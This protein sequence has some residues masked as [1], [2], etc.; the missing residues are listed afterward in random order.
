MTQARFRRT[1]A[2]SFLAAGALVPPLLIAGGASAAPLSGFGCANNDVSG[3][4][5]TLTSDCYTAH[6]LNVPDGM[7]L[8]GNGH[9]ITA[10]ETSDNSNTFA[11]AVVQSAS[12]TTTP[13]SLD[14][15][16]LN[17][18]TNF[19]LNSDQTVF[20]ISFDNARGSLT[21]VSVS[22]ITH[23]INGQTN[24]AVRVNNALTARA[25]FAVN[26]LTIRNYS[27]SGLYVNGPVDVTATAMNIGFTANPDGSQLTSLAGN[28]VTL[29]NGASGSIKNSTIAGNRY[30][31]DDAPAPADSAATAILLFNVG[32]VAVSGN[33]IIGTD[34]DVGV[35][36]LN[37]GTAP[38]AI[39]VTCNSIARTAGGHA[40][41]HYGQ[42]ITVDGTSTGPL[43]LNV[44]SNVYSGW[45]SNVSSAATAVTDPTCPVAA[46]PAPAPA[47]PVASITKS[48]SSVKHGK[49]VTFG[50]SVS[51]FQAGGRVSLQRFYSHHWHL[52]KAKGL[53]AA[54]KYHF[55]Y[56][57]SSR[58]NKYFRVVI[59]AT[60]KNLH[61]VTRTVKVHVR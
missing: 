24:R 22:G 2:L 23:G 31:T 9:T 36:A 3:T 17:I 21:N 20:G 35:D 7:T 58:G 61:G 33:S 1:A 46:P 15:K 54:G 42:A 12:G 44:G 59:A 52:V 10:V 60:S 13:A 57:T 5:V 34:S 27:K 50:G 28:S 4:T 8:D 19:G 53:T 16:N 40:D 48:K 32:T 37:T 18:A 41:T 26:G 43:A 49:Y 47:P 38:S 29:L 14:V 11:G 6:T 55:A 25:A 51:P 39:T 30:A 56:K 45:A